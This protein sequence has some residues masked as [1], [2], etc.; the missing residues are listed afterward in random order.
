[1]IGLAT[2]YTNAPVANK[3]HFPAA[4]PLTIARHYSARIPVQR[5]N[6]IYGRYIHDKNVLI[7]PYGTFITSQMLRVQQPHA[8][9]DFI[10]GRLHQVDYA[11]LI[12]E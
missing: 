2:S 12:N 4:D 10:S 1:M 11:N 5:R 8:A 7:D 3:H 6:S 9:R